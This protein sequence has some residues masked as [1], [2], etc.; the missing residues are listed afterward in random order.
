[1]LKSVLI[2]NMYNFK[3]EIILDFS[4]YDKNSQHY[5]FKKQKITSDGNG[6]D[7]TIGRISNFSIIYGKNNIGKT[8]LLNIIDQ[9]IQF[10]SGDELNLKPYKPHKD[11]DNSTFEIIVQND[12]N[13]IRYGFIL[14]IINNKIIDEWLYAKLNNSSRETELFSRKENKFHVLFNKLKK[15][16]LEIKENKLYLSVI[17]QFNSDIKVIQDFFDEIHNIHLFKSNPFNKSINGEIFHVLTDISDNKELLE[18]M[19]KCIECLDLD[20]EYVKVDSL[21]EEDSKVMERYE[22]IMKSEDYQEKKDFFSENAETFMRVI[23]QGIVSKNNEYSQVNFIHKSG[24]A[25]DYKSL[26]TGTKQMINIIISLLYNLGSTSTLLFDEIELGL[27]MD[28]VESI[29]EYFRASCEVYPKAQ[30]IITTHR[31][32]LLDLDFIPDD[33]KCFIKKN[34]EGK[35]EI[36]YLSNFLMDKKHQ[37]SKRYAMNAFGTNPDRYLEYK[38]FNILNNMKKTEG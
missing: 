34:D 23:S 28:L 14:D 30:F 29:F 9:V 5:E 37:T 27:H 12:N 26:S 33:N 35:I 6:E 38:I 22:E 19:N 32:E 7:I 17:A 21:S 13:E 4:T 18:I 20:I 15:P 2:E 3:D 16:L 8:N 24:Q 10:I 11:N 36:D 31:A 25:F 1:M